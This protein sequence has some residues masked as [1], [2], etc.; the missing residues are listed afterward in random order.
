MPLFLDRT[1]VNVE[2][3]VGYPGS[4][5]LPPRL[6]NLRYQSS[7]FGYHFRWELFESVKVCTVQLLL[8]PPNSL[9][10]LKKANFATIERV[11]PGVGWPGE[12]CTLSSCMDSATFLAIFMAFCRCTR[13]LVS[14][15]S[16]VSPSTSGTPVKM[17]LF[18]ID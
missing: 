11:F 14:V 8:L 18:I 5:A 1:T 16:G 10:V 12:R 2:G 9:A 4:F 7:T 3:I 13:S 6:F 17:R 15:T